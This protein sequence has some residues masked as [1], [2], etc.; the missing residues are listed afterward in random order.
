MQNL[1]SLSFHFSA[2]FSQIATSRAAATMLAGESTI[3]DAFAA[4]LARLLMSLWA[5]LADG[6]S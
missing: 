2:Q 1:M 3:I 5:I 6:R 4:R